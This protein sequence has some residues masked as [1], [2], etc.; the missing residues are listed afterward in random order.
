MN[1]ALS[2]Q[3]QLPTNNNQ[4]MTS[5][6]NNILNLLQFELF[7]FENYFRLKN[8]NFVPKNSNFWITQIVCVLQERYDFNEK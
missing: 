7:S 2:A 5:L 3:A 8:I 1:N 4:P 6:A